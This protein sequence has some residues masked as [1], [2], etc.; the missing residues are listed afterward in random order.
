MYFVC[1][2]NNINN[3]YVY[4]FDLI[5]INTFINFK[6]NKLSKLINII[7]DTRI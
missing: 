2:F 3:I 4:L 6:R 7:H 1:E 5:E